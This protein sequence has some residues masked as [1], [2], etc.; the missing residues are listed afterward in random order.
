MLILDVDEIPPYCDP[1][2]EPTTDVYDQEAVELLQQPAT[3]TRGYAGEGQLI[4]VMDDFIYA[5]GV[6]VGGC[7]ATGSLDT[8]RTINPCICSSEL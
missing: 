5:D 7:T 8:H 2:P 4:A 6:A 3:S 1:A